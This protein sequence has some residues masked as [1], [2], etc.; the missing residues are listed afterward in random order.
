MS[1]VKNDMR[2]NRSADGRIETRQQLKS[3][4]ER[5]ACLL[6]QKRGSEL[7][8]IFSGA[9][10]TATEALEAAVELRQVLGIDAKALGEAIEFWNR[11]RDFNGA[12][13]L[14]CIGGCQSA[15]EAMI[16]LRLLSARSFDQSAPKPVQTSTTWKP[17]TSVR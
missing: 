12:A 13:A 2:K 10:R 1:P 8:H 7:F 16:T 6:G 4:N 15:P 9:A 14:N 17:K 5:I 3:T 11:V